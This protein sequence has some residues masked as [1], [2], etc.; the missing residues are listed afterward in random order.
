MSMKSHKTIFVALIT[1]ILVSCSKERENK[2]KYTGPLM[3][4][5]ESEGD[6]ISNGE[7]LRTKIYMS[8][9][10]LFRVALAN[11][12]S[13]YLL[14]KYDTIFDEN[15]RYRESFKIPRMV[16]DTAYIEFMINIKNFNQGSILE[17]TWRADIN[18]NFK[19][20]CI[21]VDTSFVYLSTIYIKND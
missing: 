15:E 5:I 12:I 21:P 16:G 6:T 20:D 14:I 4:I 11:G 17:Y 19:S 18:L 2:D 10:S 3:P 9:D 13:N 1:L 8:N 7:L